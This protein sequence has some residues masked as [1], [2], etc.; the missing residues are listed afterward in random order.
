MARTPS[1]NLDVGNSNI[2]QTVVAHTDEP[3][4]DHLQYKYMVRCDDP[5]GCAGREAP[6]GINGSDFH[7]RK[8][9]I[10]QGNTPGL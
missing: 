10:C 1:A 3:G 5:A 8:C 9:P 6:Y 7:H 4:T 2:R